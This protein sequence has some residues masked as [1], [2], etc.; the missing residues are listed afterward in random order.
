[1]GPTYST[2]G[3]RGMLRGT[4]HVPEDVQ[5]RDGRPQ[6]AEDEP[7]PGQP[8]RPAGARAAERP[9]LPSQDNRRRRARPPRRPHP[10]RAAQTPRVAIAG[11][12]EST[13][14]ARPDDHQARPG[15]WA[16]QDQRAWNGHRAARR[17]PRTGASAGPARPP[18]RG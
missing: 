7:T 6:Q 4:R 5:A 3:A 18:T 14:L 17:A 13:S 1:M 9:P 8:P 11:P 10:G 16:E 15:D 12:P 2:P